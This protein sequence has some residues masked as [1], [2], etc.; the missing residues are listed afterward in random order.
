[1]GISVSDFDLWKLTH[2]DR[3]RDFGRLSVMTKGGLHDDLGNTRVIDPWF[4][5]TILILS[6]FCRNNR[7]P[8]RSCRLLTINNT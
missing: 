7:A 6:I 5:D 2:Q 1:M 4:L 8:Y 3:R